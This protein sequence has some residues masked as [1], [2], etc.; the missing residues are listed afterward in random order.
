[1]EHAITLNKTAVG[2]APRQPFVMDTTFVL[3]FLAVDFGFSVTF[4]GLDGI[5]SLVTL[6]MFVFVPYL[7][8]SVDE[9]PEFGHWVL[10]RA[11]IAVFAV[12]LGVMLRQAIG[13]VI[14]EGFRYVP[15]TLLIGSSIFCGFT[16]IYGMIRFRLAG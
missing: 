6:V 2:R 11:A 12:F 4:S 16:Q 13:T 7:L 9:K 5:L 3:F 8:P 15:M 10:G 14:P 1:M